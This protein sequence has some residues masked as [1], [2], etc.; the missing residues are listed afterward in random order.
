MNVLALNVGEDRV[1]RG[2]EKF[3]CCLD[4]PAFGIKKVWRHYLVAGLPAHK[5][6]HSRQRG[7]RCSLVLT[8]LLHKCEGLGRCSLCAPPSSK[9]GWVGGGTLTE[10]LGT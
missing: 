4:A 3:A 2:S 5:R 6:A 8:V 1:Q 9:L 7:P 10:E